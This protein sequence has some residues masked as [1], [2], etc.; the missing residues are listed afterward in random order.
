MDRKTLIDK[1]VNDAATWDQENLI[2]Y[3][4]EELR[5][6]YTALSN[7]ELKNEYCAIFSE[8]LTEEE[9]AALP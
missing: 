2:G 8:L 6:K 1:L 4:Q 5:K 7:A 3:V 9:E